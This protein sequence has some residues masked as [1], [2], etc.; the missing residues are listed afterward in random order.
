MEQRKPSGALDVSLH[1]SLGISVVPELAF[2]LGGPTTASLTF[3]PLGAGSG[4]TLS[5]QLAPQVASPP[6]TAKA[7]SQLVEDWIL[8][9]VADL[10]I[11][12]TGTKFDQ[13]IYLNGP[14]T[15]TLLSKAKVITG[16]GPAPKYSLK[17][18]LP[19]VASVLTSLLQSLPAT[20][21]TLASSPPLTMTLGNLGHGQLGGAIKGSI[22]IATGDP[23]IDLVFGAPSG[24]HNVSGLPSGVQL[25]LFTTGATTS[26]APALVGG[27]GAGFA[28][29]GDHPLINEAGVRIG[30]IDGF[31]ALNFD[32]IRGKTTNGLGAGLAIG[33]LGLPLGLLDTVT[34]SNPVAA[35]ILGSNTGPGKGDA[36][37]VNPAVDVL[38]TYLN[39][40]LLIQL[41]GTRQPIVVPVHANFGPLYIAQIDLAVAGT[42]AVTLGVDGSVSIDGLSVGLDDLALQ[43]PVRSVLT[44]LDWSLDLQGLAVGFNSGPVEIS[45]GLRKN[46]GS[47][48]E[49][50]GM[51]SAQIAD[52]GFTVVGAYSQRTDAQGGYTSL[53]MFVS[54][55]IP[56]GGPPFA[57]ITGLGGGFGYNRELVI[58][59]DMNQ[60]DSFILVEAIDDDT[61]ANDPLNALIKMGQQIPARRGALWIAAGVRFT[62]FALINSVVVVSIAFDRG[63]DIEILGVSR[64]ALPS[65]N[66]AL[67]SVELALRARYNSAEQT[68]SVQAQLTDNSYLFSRDCQLTGGFAFAIWYGDGQFVLTLGGYNPLFTKPP[69]F[70]DVPRLGYHWSVS[71]NI[72]IKGESYF[73]LTNSCV[74]AG[75]SLSA[76]ASIG[77]VSAW[78]DA[79][80]DFL[81]CWDPFHYEFD[82]GVEIGASF[83]VT[84]CFFACA[85]FSVS[86]SLGAQLMIE[87]PPFHGT[88]SIDVAVAHVTIAFGDSPQQPAH[89]TDFDR[90]FKPKYLTAGDPNGSAVSVQ[91]THGVLPVDP[92]GAQPLPGTKTQ[93]WQLGLEFTLATTT[94]MPA[95]STSAVPLPVNKKPPPDPPTWYGAPINLPAPGDLNELDVA[96]MGLSRISSIHYVTLQQKTAGGWQ[97]P[98]ITDG[99]DHFTVTATTGFFPEATWR[100]PDDPNHIPAAARTITAIAGITIDAHIKL[101]NESAPIPISTL[102]ADKPLDAKPLPLAAAVIT[103]LP[104]QAFGGEADALAAAVAS[105]ASSKF[106]LAGAA[107]LSGT[108]IF[109]A[110]RTAL[111]L[112]AAGLGPLAAQA[113]HTQRSAPPLLTPLTTGLSM[114]PVGLPAPIRA[115]T[116]AP[117]DSVLLTQPR[118]RAVLQSVAAAVTDAPPARHT[119]VSGLLPSVLQASPRMAP[120]GSLTAPS[121]P[122]ARLLLVPAATAP[123][124]TRA[125][126]PARAIRN[127]DLGAATGHAHQQALEQAAADLVAAG[128][129]LAAGATHLWDV[130]DDTGQFSITGSG[131]VRMVCTDR[132]GSPLRD[133]E[134]VADG[135]PAQPVPAGTARVA[136]TCLGRLPSDTTPPNPGFGSL[137]GTFAPTGQPAVL[138]WQSASTLTQ[139]GPALFLARGATL[140]V[141]RPHATSRNGQKASYGTPRAADVVNT[142]LGVE[143]RLP[144]GVEVVAI[145]LDVQDPTAAQ[146]G[147]LALAVTGAT[148]AATPQRVITSNRR[149]LLYDVATRD[150]AAAALLTSIASV[151]GYRVG[152]VLGLRGN[153]TEWANR[154]SAGVPDLFVPDGAVSP[155]GSLTVTYTGAHP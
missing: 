131:A 1:S 143:T 148:L 80:V 63:L 46:P 152:A 117:T 84:V 51:L 86:V 14:S 91:I 108:N 56:L 124:P 34:T 144:S 54:L 9:L 64:M 3:L 101:N 132:T 149:L 12:A 119:S 5:L 19:S 71:D 4:S 18:P 137:T 70:P 36:A 79:Y 21:I 49:Y 97:A 28:G 42:D 43:I 121:A 66:I 146:T 27:I 134:F 93:P 110:N 90:V 7:A 32:L 48:V 123:Q 85:T 109:A 39:G 53:F 47:Q 83:S 96:P 138:G 75:N 105:A 125:A 11:A 69:Q 45:G 20:S 26:F 65:E 38:V 40:A 25:T 60:I 10:L 44:P 74:M 13:P 99:Q 87:G 135:S 57:F 154:L 102:I 140:R 127:A 116:V 17:T 31:V 113:L 115:A 78:F 88:V 114:K 41:A 24:I 103:I 76:T 82:I 136:I 120:P 67:A 107:I 55:P 58:P 111:G 147:D 22:T 142:Q 139:I 133:T 52:I 50:D 72:T 118:L 106:I 6:P 2:S 150:P 151:T 129:T 33:Q 68:L 130:P 35:S 89:I 122:G 112:P 59:T 145:A 95:S 128:V 126:T 16:T 61:L 98:T 77:P 141:I 81:I 104:M 29:D 23:T 73:A 30:S 153:A 92:P 62:S 155:D 100:C 37:P 8:P 15:A 94:R